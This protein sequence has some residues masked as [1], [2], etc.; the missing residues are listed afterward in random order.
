MDNKS[1]DEFQVTLT[2]K[3]IGIIIAA[4][5]SIIK[6]GVFQILHPDLNQ[7][8]ADIRKTMARTYD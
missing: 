6:S 2:R 4:I 5:E 8:I 1:T 3:Q 7:I